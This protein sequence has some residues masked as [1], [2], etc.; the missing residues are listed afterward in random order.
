MKKITFLLFALF[1]SLAASQ[2]QV[3]SPLQAGHYF[4]GVINVRDMSTP[5]PGMFFILY[6]TYLWTHTYIDRNGDKFNGIDLSQLDPRL[7]DLDVDMDILS[8]SATPLIE[9]ASPFKILGATYATLLSLP[10]YSFSDARVL[11]E[12]GF[13]QIDTTVTKSSNSKTSGFGDLMFQPLGL[14]WTTSSFNFMLDYAFY[15]PTGRYTTG[16]NN[17]TGLG[18][19]THQFQGFGYFFPVED[20]STAL[21]LGL[22]FET[23][24]S[25][26][27]ARVKP[28]NRF[29]L[30]WGLSRYGIFSYIY[31]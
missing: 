30:E 27:D 19:W 21:M 7:P 9:W 3:V 10:G 20:Q 16:G 17:N 8:F 6:D 29:T 15:A 31:Q 5:P 14:A 25:I 12:L 13:G 11:G 26:T 1:L 24:S 4:P 28:G 22:T 2:A 18:Y 23:N